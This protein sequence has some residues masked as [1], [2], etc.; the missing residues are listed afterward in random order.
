MEPFHVQEPFV[1]N[2]PEVKSPGSP[3]TSGDSHCPMTEQIPAPGSGS[4][5]DGRLLVSCHQNT[6]LLENLLH[7]P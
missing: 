7:K 4:L 2:M 1:V 3:G 6:F 5:P